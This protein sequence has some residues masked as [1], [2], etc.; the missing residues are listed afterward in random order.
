MDRQID[1]LTGLIN[2]LLDVVRI[3]GGRIEYTDEAV[4]LNAVVR[5]AVADVQPTASK[6]LI[7]VEGTIAGLAWGDR[8]RIGQVI[9]NLLT[10]AV[11]YSPQ[12]DRVL[13]RLGTDERGAT[14]AVQDFGIG[15]A[16]EHMQH[17][18]EQFY[19]VS[20]PSEKTFPGLG[21][22][23]YIA[24]EIVRR[25]GGEIRVESAPGAGT[26]FTVALP[27]S[28]RDAAGSGATGGAQD[29]HQAEARAG[30]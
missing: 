18:F 11:K 23:L 3:Q 20:D 6:H 14:I 25:H 2:D 10:N 5:E 28:R 17:L 4:D 27:L 12:A 1:K 21:I 30:R 7:A 24:G 9:T 15:I 22:G 8:E 13:V 19:R 29:G 26:T 16:A